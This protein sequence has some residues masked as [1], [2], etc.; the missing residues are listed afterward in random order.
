MVGE[1]DFVEVVH[2]ELSHK[3]RV[4]VVAVVARE[5]VLFQF[6]LVEDPDALE[7]SVPVDDLGI[8]FGLD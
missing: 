3:G 5:D 6:F 7:L 2:V 1:M 8:L 4:S